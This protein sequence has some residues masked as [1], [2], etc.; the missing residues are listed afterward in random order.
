MLEQI[1]IKCLLEHFNQKIKELTLIRHESNAADARKES[2]R[3]I[4]PRLGAKVVNF[5]FKEPVLTSPRKTLTGLELSATLCGFVTP[6][7]SR[8]TTSSFL[9]K[10]KLS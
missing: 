8:M 5:G 3:M 4:V 6:V 9:Q 10:P 2:N 1:S 7:S